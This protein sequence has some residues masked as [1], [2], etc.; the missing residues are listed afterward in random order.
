ME[1]STYTPLHEAAKNG[2]FSVCQLIVNN[3]KDL[4]PLNWEGKTPFDL[5]EEEGHEEICNLIDS[6]IKNQ[7][8]TSTMAKKR[9]MN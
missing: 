6:A 3:T 8:E 5:A 4:K 2:H 1:F 7:N 9:K